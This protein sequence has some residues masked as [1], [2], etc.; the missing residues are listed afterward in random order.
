MPLSVRHRG[1]VAKISVKISNGDRCARLETA[2]TGETEMKSQTVVSRCGNSFDFSIRAG[3][4]GFGVR[5]LGLSETEVDRLM[6][7]NFTHDL[8][9]RLLYEI[10]IQELRARRR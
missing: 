2:P 3:G 1:L 6:R 4:G 5:I 7:V 10:S 8:R 9:A